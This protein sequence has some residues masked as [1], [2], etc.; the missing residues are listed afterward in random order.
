MA[1]S[2]RTHVEQDTSKHALGHI[3]AKL[4][5]Q[6]KTRTVF[7]VVEG[8]DD[9]AF[10]KR[11]FKD[12]ITSMYYSTRLTEN[13]E[14]RP[15]GCK[16]LQNIVKAVLED[17]RTDRIVGIMDTDYRRY[18]KGYVYP[19][20]IYHTDHRD[21]EMT[22]ISTQSVQLALKNWMG[23]YDVVMSQLEPVLR[24][25]GA[26]RVVNDVY[27]I[28]CNFQKQAKIIKVFDQKN[29]V[30]YN[31][32]KK[33]YIILFLRGCFK[34]KNTFKKKVLTLISLCKALFH[35][36]CYPYKEESFYDISRGHDV[37]KLLSVMS[38][39]TAVYSEDNIWEKCFD[40]YS[41]SDFK[42]TELYSA[43]HE[44][45]IKRNLSI[46]RI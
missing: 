39:H 26:L 25:I 31:D 2:T 19:Q 15:G 27:N 9:L 1:T 42:C 3:F 13:G 7:V 30:L 44:W 36:I 29:Q 22:T 6:N 40:A 14:M 43:I 33:R 41:L 21:M 17:G 11:F 34:K 45:E 4:N 12:G 18:K 32:W 8:S 37:L 46:L 28:G 5:G 35:F 10:Y 24:H 16:E 38:I 20:N 23:K